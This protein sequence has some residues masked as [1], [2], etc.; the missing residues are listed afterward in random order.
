MVSDGA[1]EY[2]LIVVMQAQFC[3]IHE[4]QTQIPILFTEDFHG[5]SLHQNERPQDFRLL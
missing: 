2:P 5:L 4:H 1:A 3:H